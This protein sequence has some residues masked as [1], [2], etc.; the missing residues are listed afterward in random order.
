MIQREIEKQIIKRAFSGKAIIVLGARQTGK[1]TLVKQIAAQIGVKALWFTG[2]DYISRESLE[3]Q[4][5]ANI[6]SLIGTHKLVIIDEAQ[7]INNIGLTL[8]IIVDNMPD[9]QVIATGSSSFELLSAVNEPLTGRKWEYL[10]YPISYNELIKHYG[11][12]H[13]K[14]MLKHRLVY[15]SY[16]EVVDQSGNEIELLKLLSGSYLYKDLF[17]H[18]QIKKPQLL[19]KLV[20]ALAFQ[21]CSEVSYNE[22]S[23]TVGADIQTIEKY[24]D[25]LEKAFIVFRMYA[26]SR[27]LRNEIKKS[28][29]IYFY[30]N[31]IRN[32]VIGNFL[33]IESRAD[34]GALW[35]NYFIAERQKYLKY[36]KDYSNYYFWRTH[37]QQEIDY[38]EEKD[39][40][41]KAFEIKWNK[42]KKVKFP[43]SFLQAY[44]NSKTTIVHPGNFGEF[45]IGG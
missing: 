35:E 43:S 3:N 31:G 37:T 19:E 1:T 34:T 12:I 24:I 17:M 2:D 13:E 6:K 14:G 11:I 41:I 20:R 38:I 22:L 32:A 10:L 36:I 18:E 45:L 7:Y 29:K 15:G 21:V 26:L 16:P 8:K 33:P 4:S 27:N 25:M 42:D 5:V 40:M 39:G 9:V 44:P 28:R 23:Q 30:D